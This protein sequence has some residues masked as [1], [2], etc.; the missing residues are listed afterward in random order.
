[1]PYSENWTIPAGT[2]TYDRPSDWNPE[3]CIIEAWGAGA[4]GGRLISLGGGSFRATTGGM[5]GSYAANAGTTDE[6]LE[7]PAAFVCTVADDTDPATDENIVPG[8]ATSLLGE[9]GTP[10]VLA[11]GGGSSSASVGDV[12]Y[13][14]GGFG[15]AQHGGGDGAGGPHGTGVT[16]TSNGGAG[17][18]GS[19]GTGGGLNVNGSDNANGGGGSGRNTTD[20]TTLYGGFPGG[21]SGTVT[22][23]LATAFSQGRAG[24]LVLRWN[25]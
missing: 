12:T 4:S 13:R 14:G 10:V 6:P 8:G 23:T 18:N 21:G 5:G 9:P 15:S 3:D 1:M 7:L 20:G 2:D 11:A 25:P 16:G 19:G 24:T 17:D 22:N